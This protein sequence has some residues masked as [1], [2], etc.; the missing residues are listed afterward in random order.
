MVQKV[1]KRDGEIVDFDISRIVNAIYQAFVSI[2]KD[3]LQYAKDLADKVVDY[4]T[5]MKIEIPNIED[6][7][8]VIEKVLIEE[9]DVEI[10]KEFI[11]Y[12]YRRSLVRGK[13]SVKNSKKV[14]KL[15]E[16]DIFLSP[17]AI[18]IL[19]DSSSLSEL[20]QLIFLDRYSMDA[21]R[22]EIKR[23]DLVIAITKEDPKYPK[24]EPAI[25]LNKI[26]QDKVELYL[27]NSEDKFIQSL[28]KIDKPSE[29]VSDCYQRVA[30][31]V[32]SVEK[33]KQDKIIWEKKFLEQLEN[34]HLQPAGRIM[35]GANVDDTG[36]YISNLTLYNCYVIPSPQDSRHGIIKTL[37]TMT[38]VMSRGGGVGICLSTLR[39]R[40]SY[41][42]GVNGKSSGS[43]SWGGLYSFATGLIEQGGSRRGALMLTLDDW[44]PDILEFIASK[45]EK[46]MIENANI[47]VKISDS[48]MNAVKEDQKWFLEYPEYENPQ[49]K[50]IYEN[51][52]EGDLKSW[53]EKGYPTKVYKEINAREMWDLII[54]SAHKSAEPGIIFMERYNKLSNSWYYNRIICTNPC[55]EQGLP[56]WGVCNLGH[57]YLASFAKQVGTDPLGKVYEMDWSELKKS[58]KILTRFLDN[59]IDLTPYH[60]KENEENQKSERRIGGGTLGLAEL[61]IKLRIPYGSEDSINF[62]D[63]LYKTIIAEMYLE[64]SE[65]AKE[66]GAFP[67]F[68]KEKFLQ[69]GFVQNLPD[70]VKEA[71]R[72]NGIRNVSL[73]TQA[74]TGTVGTMLGTSTGIEPYYDF[75]YYRQSRLG[76][77]KQV[78][79]I[80]KEY[81]QEDGTLPNFFVKAMDLKP[82]D[83]VKVQAAIQRWT[84]SSIS[85]TANAPSNFT[86]EDTKKLYELAYDLGCKGLTIYVDNSRTEQILSTSKETEEKNIKSSQKTEE[87]ITE[88]KKI[89]VSEP[90]NEP[91][92]G[93]KPGNRCPACK[94]GIMVKVG[95]CTECSSQ[96]GFKGSCDV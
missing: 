44:H 48:F 16:S 9:S 21:P 69:S 19:N 30:H 38:E 26:D 74:P 66:K 64:S 43:V 76:F 35:A 85:K 91:V 46:G 94:K 29:S 27:L 45:K 86:V 82:E 83:H 59:I 8:D 70:E 24:K 79:D 15:L 65:L 13:K 14:T 73:N 23:G 2:G 62:I 67:K 81:Q 32:A 75:V 61:L 37:G 95:G 47:S 53:K 89:E 34:K 10:A 31:A 93:P 55:G 50:E 41:I 71:I 51:E 22:S 78:M 88:D 5:L 25:V 39:P 87:E 96:C 54:S 7:Q 60:F 72:N 42:N 56:A 11:I 1:Q 6:I 17:Q 84:D 49:I 28:W 80:A 57:L 63:K 4:L 68:D 12:R 92:Y 20:G 90:K 77:H 40:Y 36:K 33:E 3:D 18:S 52:W 58:V